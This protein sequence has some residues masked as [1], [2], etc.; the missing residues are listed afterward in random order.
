MRTTFGRRG[1]LAASVFV[2]L[3]PAGQRVARAQG[4]S[5]ALEEILVTARRREESLQDYV[6]WCEDQIQMLR[7]VIASLIGRHPE[8]FIGEDLEHLEEHG[9]LPRRN[10]YT[11]L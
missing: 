7:T 1:V 3:L 6:L 8:L 9:F 4:A 5:D 2:A 10:E 11:P